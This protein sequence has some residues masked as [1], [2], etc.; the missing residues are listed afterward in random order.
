M[1]YKQRNYDVSTEGIMNTLQ[2]AQSITGRILCAAFAA[3]CLASAAGA[4]TA[5]RSAAA[6]EAPAGLEEI[7]V[8]AQ[9]REQNSQD[10]GISLSAVTGKELQDLGVITASD[11]T[12]SMPAVVL[13]Q[14]NGPSSFSLV[15]PRSHAERLRR[16]PGEPGG[17]LRRRRLREPDGGPRLLAVRHRPR[18]GAARSAGHAVRPQCDRR[19]REFVS[20]RPTDDHE[21][22]RQR[23]HR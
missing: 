11:I 20:R 3:I 16:P 10:V 21:R 15:D 12:K 17:D 1:A 19:S 7:V 8:T 6:A 18:R 9:K 13:T 2:R 14:P 4:Q 22:L 23:D 5:T